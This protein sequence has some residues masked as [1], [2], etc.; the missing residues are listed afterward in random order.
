MT[1]TPPLE[2]ARQHG[3][4]SLS[5]E[6]AVMTIN[7]RKRTP[8]YKAKKKAQRSKPEARAKANAYRR[9]PTTPEQRLK[10]RARE[11]AKLA[12][13]QGRIVRPPCCELCGAPDVPKSNGTS[14][15][16]ADHY[17]GYD[18]PRTVRFV[19]ADCDGRQERER[20]NTTLGR[21]WA[22]DMV[23]RRRRLVKPEQLSETLVPIYRRTG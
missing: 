3:T 20:G 17:M 4:I 11:K 19:C 8:E 12:I 13:K 9:L 10:D 23:A 21:V 16:R 5:C 2:I 14:G 6:V 22:M 1:T 7:E 18:H 15:L